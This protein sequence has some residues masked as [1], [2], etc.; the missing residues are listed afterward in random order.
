[1]DG[2]IN[3][4]AKNL[5]SSATMF[6]SGPRA[7]EVADL[8]G[9]HVRVR[10]LGHEFGRASAMKML[11]SGLSKGVCALFAETALTA[12]R[13]MAKTAVELLVSPS[14]REAVHTEWASRSTG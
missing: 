5:T 2:A 11:L 8:F 7:S 13:A 9:Q 4:L 12:A 3:G 1:M 14:L 6:L 10:L